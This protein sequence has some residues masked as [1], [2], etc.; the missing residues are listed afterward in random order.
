MALSDI[1]ASTHLLAALVL[2]SRLGDIVST[3]LI[4][5]RLRLEANPVVRRLGWPFAT[6]TLLVALVPYVDM[7]AGVVVLVPSLLVAASNLSRGW[8][9]RALGE[10]EFEELLLRAARRG[11]RGEAVAFMAAGGAFIVLAGLALMWMAGQQSW[12]YWFGF[13]IIVY[14]AVIVVHGSLFVLRLF[15]RAQRADAT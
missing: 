12:G 4:T 13:G 8:L 9:V 6:A 2:V 3:R 10:A 5:P 1:D 14:G 15:R 7:V 11:R